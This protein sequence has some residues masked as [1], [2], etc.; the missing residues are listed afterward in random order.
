MLLYRKDFTLG[1]LD[2]HHYIENIVGY[3]EDCFIEVLSLITFYC[4]Y[5]FCWDMAYSLLYWEYCYIEDRYISVPLYKRENLHNS[6]PL[7]HKLALHKKSSA[8]AYVRKKK[9]KQT[10]QIII[11]TLYKFIFVFSYIVVPRCSLITRH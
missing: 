7:A 8:A 5:N 10:M 2:S 11:F 1:Q 3:I 6:D 4:W 9:R